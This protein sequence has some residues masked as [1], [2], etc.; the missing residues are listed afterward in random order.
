MKLSEL[1]NFLES[2]P[3]DAV[4]KGTYGQD[5]Y[6]YI[7]EELYEGDEEYTKTSLILIEDV[8]SEFFKDRKLI[9]FESVGDLLDSIN[10]ND[11]DLEDHV[12]VEYST[13]DDEEV[14]HMLVSVRH[15]D[16]DKETNSVVVNKFHSEK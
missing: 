7:V 12:A 9:G 16:Y 10:A 6:Q 1:V 4:L 11:Y 8:D 5:I 13:A 14:E 15:V 3:S 2:C